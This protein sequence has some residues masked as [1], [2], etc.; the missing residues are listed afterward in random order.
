MS[1]LWWVVSSNGQES[2]L[3]QSLLAWHGKCVSIQSI[4]IHNYI[5]PIMFVWTRISSLMVLKDPQ[6]HSEFFT[7][8]VSLLQ[9]PCIFASKDLHWDPGLLKL[10]CLRHREPEVSGMTCW[11]QACVR[12][13]KTSSLALNWH[14]LWNLTYMPGLYKIRCSNLLWDFTWNHILAWFLSLFFFVSS[15]H[16]RFFLGTFP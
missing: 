5:S 3:F 4:Q 11:W 6:I 1:P 7:L 14:Q 9:L 16:F 8:S 15:T 10:T 12:V 2:W 13:W